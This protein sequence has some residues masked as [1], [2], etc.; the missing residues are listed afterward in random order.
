MLI[1]NSQTM[2][3]SPVNLSP[4]KGA[5]RWPMILGT[6]IT[7]TALVL[8]IVIAIAPNIQPTGS[9]LSPLPEGIITEETL[10][11][12]AA[13]SAAI[14]AS[15]A[16]ARAS[17]SPSTSSSA[18]L[19]SSANKQIIAFPARAKEFSVTDPMVTDNSYIYLTPLSDTTNS[20]LSVKSKGQG[21]FTIAIDSPVEADLLLNYYV[22]LD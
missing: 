19:N 22:I 1:E 11:T 13:T 21:Y 14:I 4:E 2:V 10:P 7:L 5:Y 3:T 12:P 8:P 18:T 17:A 9:L 20:T 6:I 15:D 16:I